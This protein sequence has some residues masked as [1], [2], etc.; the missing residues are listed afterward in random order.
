MRIFRDIDIR[1]RGDTARVRSTVVQDN[2]PTLDEAAFKRLCAN[3]GW[4]LGREL[5]IVAM[6]P[7]LE[8]EKE[9]QAG[10]PLDEDDGEL[11]RYIERNPEVQT[12]KID[13]GHSG[14]II[15]K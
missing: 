7:T 9:I 15:V 13:S 2:T 11:R 14:R 12:C 10:R 3:N 1:R 5:R 6:I 4:S 8:Y